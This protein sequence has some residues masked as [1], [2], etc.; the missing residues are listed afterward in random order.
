MFCALAII[1]LFTSSYSSAGGM[2]LSYGIC[3]PFSFRPL[4]GKFCSFIETVSH[5]RRPLS[6]QPNHSK[7]EVEKPSRYTQFRGFLSSCYAQLPA[8]SEVGSYVSTKIG[9]G[10]AASSG[11]Q[12]ALVV[13]EN[14]VVVIEP[15]LV[16]AA[17]ESRVNIQAGKKMMGQIGSTCY[18]YW[19]AVLGPTFYL[20]GGTNVIVKTAGKQLK[21]TLVQPVIE[22]AKTLEAKFELKIDETKRYMEEKY[23]A[24][25]KDLEA[26]D[27]KFKENFLY[28]TGAFVACGISAVALKCA[29]T[30]IKEYMNRPVLEY[31]KGNP[32]S[33]LSTTGEIGFEDMVF[34]GD[35][36]SRLRNLLVSVCALTTKKSNNPADS[37][38]FT[39]LL[40]HGPTGLGKRS[41]VQELASYA[42][43]ELYEIKSSSLVSFKNNDANRA[44][45]DFFDEVS[46]FLKPAIIYID[47]ASVLF[48]KYRTTNPSD[49]GRMIQAFVEKT[50]QRSS[51][52]MLVLSIPG[53]P[54]SDNDMFPVMDEIVEFKLPELHERLKMLQVYRDKLLLT[55]KDVTTPFAELAKDLLNEEALKT[56][57]RQLDNFSSADI[58]ALIKAIKTEALEVY[59]GVLSK[60]LIDQVVAR[61]ILRYQPACKGAAIDME[62]SQ[63]TISDF[64]KLSDF[65]LPSASTLPVVLSTSNTL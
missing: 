35:L 24:G 19:P 20:K 62:S 15:P 33:A 64:G 65:K 51:K 32:K 6:A 40:L 12:E 59:N 39:T 63:T 52:F 42:D 4:L 50:E 29:W 2:T 46:Q 31:S 1:A 16:P 49:I 58:A 37:T 48:S 22:E 3:F 56:I 23:E 34:E 18:S 44:L 10:K 53:K 36:K 17:E 60:E 25:K 41:F 21:Q 8:A 30:Q 26:A 47:N 28:A 5:D 9:F 57:A 45:K 38:L 54:L 13:E 27:K 43:M 7:E 11:P 14:P 55:A 61:K